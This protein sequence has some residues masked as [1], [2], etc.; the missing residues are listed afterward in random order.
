MGLGTNGTHSSQTEIPNRNFPKFFVNGKRP[1]SPEP[2]DSRA[3]PRRLRDEKRA[4]GDEND[5]YLIYITLPRL[6][7]ADT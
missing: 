2:F 6:R 5:C 3:R 4:Y 1:M 7:A